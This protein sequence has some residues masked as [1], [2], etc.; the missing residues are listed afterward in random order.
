M[1]TL[2][3][4]LWISAWLLGSGVSALAA[5]LKNAAITGSYVETR[6]AEVFAGPCMANSEV[7]L[8]GDQA[9]LAWHI[10]EGSWQG[11][12]LGGMGVAA[13][14]KASGTIGAPD[15]N[16][17]PAKAVLLVDERATPEQRQALESFARARAGRLLDEVV[18][19]IAAP[20]SYEEREHGAVLFTA[21]EIVRVE[22]RNM[23]AGDHLCGNEGL[24]YLPLTK[25]S[26]SMPVYT[27]MERFTGKGLGVTWSISGKTSS[28][29]GSF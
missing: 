15:S 9:I 14:V 25:L 13:A 20:I 2:V 29:V 6:S 17:Y 7:N 26:H 22:T 19:V 5:D 21:G 16:P 23:Q 10:A 24:C 18:S 1:K 28:F 3:G 8:V 4:T 12:P 27:L 11:V